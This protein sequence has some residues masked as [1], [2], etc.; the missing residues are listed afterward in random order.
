MTGSTAISSGQ[1]ES[2]Q[3]LTAR[4][5]ILS[6][7]LIVFFGG[8]NLILVQWVLTREMTTLLLGTELVVLLVSIAYFAGLSV[9]YLLAGPVRRTWL[10]PLGVLTLVLHLTLPVWFRLLVMWLASANLYGAAFVVL[11]LLTPF[12]ISAFYSIFLP[13]F[14]DNNTGQ[15]P[16]LYALELLGSVSGVLVLVAL[17]GL[18][19][20]MVYTVYMVGLLMLLWALGMAERWLLLLAIVSG[21]WLLALP[22]L[23]FWSNALLYEQLQDLPAGSKTLFTAYSSY[24]K[25]DILETPDGARYLF[26][27]GLQH[28]GGMSG[29][30]LNVVE[31]QI[32][33]LLVRPQNAL[34]IGAGSMEMAAMI[35]DHAGHVT[36][37]EIDPVVVDAS[38]RYFD[39]FNRMSI[40]TNR[41]IIID[42]AKHFIANTPERY[43]LIATDL[44]AAHSLQTATLYSVPFYQATAD[45]L[46]PGG[47]LAANLT[48]TFAFDDIVS[49]RVV[50]S[51]LA[52]FDEVMVVTPE[53]AG[54]SFAY[55]SDDL[56]FDRQTLEAALRASGEVQFVIFETPA[57]KAFV[58]DAP[59]IT[60]DSMD[61][62]LQVSGEW[63]ADRM[64]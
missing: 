19:L 49:R 33:A 17:G 63:I 27:D 26:L 5:P 62:V 57:V 59:P 51:L 1:S 64:R 61:I 48:S 28:F 40:L 41:S 45:H 47:V 8:V 20:S 32:P 6:P 16:S 4:T 29:S 35:A 24:Q 46:T 39:E 21:V 25:I 38:L 54:W 58:G 30:R 34:V 9:G 52:A 15:L 31:G 13:L 12:V 53:S 55:A 56:P 42:D 23:N 18:G 7:L 36:T 14:I 44:P 11:P 60:L 10:V 37:V 50:A 3:A 43:D 22:G 2:R